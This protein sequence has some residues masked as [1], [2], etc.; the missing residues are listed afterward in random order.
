MEILNISKP[1]EGWVKGPKLPLESPS[2]ASNMRMFTSP[3]EK[4]VILNN[5]QQFIELSGNSIEQLTWK[6]LDHKL[7][8]SRFGHVAF[9]IPDDTGILRTIEERKRQNQTK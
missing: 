7:Q 4:G 3:T 5:G 2:E 9:P 8:I 1:N 6:I